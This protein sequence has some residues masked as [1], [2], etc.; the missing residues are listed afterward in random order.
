MDTRHPL[1]KRKLP[2]KHLVNIEKH[3]SF[4]KPQEWPNRFE[5]TAIQKTEKPAAS[6]FIRAA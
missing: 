4:R 2:T 5:E 1:Q 3:L 6:D